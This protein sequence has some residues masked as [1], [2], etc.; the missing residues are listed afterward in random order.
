MS[1]QLALRKRY[2]VSQRALNLQKLHSDPGIAGNNHCRPWVSLGRRHTCSSLWRGLCC[3]RFRW[4]PLHPLIS[5]PPP[6]EDLVHH[7][8]DMILTRRSCMAATLQ[9]I[10]EDFPEVLMFGWRARRM[11]CREKVSLRLSTVMV[12]LTLAPQSC[13]P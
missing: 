2:D 9:I 6:P 5:L 10:Q 13:S 8:I 7:G 4:T 11:E 12:T 3:G 1:L